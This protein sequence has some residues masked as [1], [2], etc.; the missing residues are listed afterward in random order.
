M[1][2]TGCEQ[3]ADAPKKSRNLAPKHN[4]LPPATDMVILGERKDPENLS[5][6]SAGGSLGST[7]SFDSVSLKCSVHS[8]NNSGVSLE[9]LQSHEGLRMDES[10]KEKTKTF[11]TSVRAPTPYPSRISHAYTETRDQVAHNAMIN[12]FYQEVLTD[13]LL[14]FF[15]ISQDIVYTDVQDKVLQFLQER[16]SVASKQEREDLQNF[17]ARTIVEAVVQQINAALSQAIQQCLSG[18]QFLALLESSEDYGEDGSLAG[19]SPEDPLITPSAMGRLR[20]LK[21]RFNCAIC[22]ISERVRNMSSCLKVTYKKAQQE[23]GLVVDLP[24]P[25]DKGTEV[26]LEKTASSKSSA[27]AISEW[28]LYHQEVVPDSPV[29]SETSVA[30]SKSDS[31]AKLSDAEA[32]SLS[33]QAVSGIPL[34]SEDEL[35]PERRLEILLSGIIRP[36]TN[37]LVNQLGRLLLVSGP[38][39]A[40]SVGGHSQSDSALPAS[41]MTGEP[42]TEISKEG[43]LAVAYALTEKS[44]Q[45]L[46]ER[47]LIALL[48]PSPVVES[49]TSCQDI[50]P[51]A[52]QQRIGSEV[53]QGCCNPLSVICRTIIDICKISRQV[54]EAVS[55][56]DLGLPVE[57]VDEM[58]SSHT[59]SV[60]TDSTPSV[61]LTK[62]DCCSSLQDKSSSQV[63]TSR[64]T[65]PSLTLNKFKKVNQVGVSPLP[66]MQHEETE[67]PA[68]ISYYSSF[69]TTTPDMASEQDEDCDSSRIQRNPSFLIR[70]YSTIEKP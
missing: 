44:I 35:S 33:E 51:A 48:P 13:P 62:C 27:T 56:V 37:M 18:T 19:V 25:A 10:A 46:L 15:G 55:E 17:S 29:C 58:F 39:K 68:E 36:H 1:E 45:A 49:A 61:S 23:Q 64:F 5:S 69:T 43:L 41:R 63:K 59:A 20:L 34:E 65:F 3:C 7:P 28:S 26:S 16:H 6:S 42:Q 57:N 38:P 70:I 52:A 47:L 50:G 8:G 21:L 2:K 4:G 24:A 40:S 60:H 66:T 32:L 12:Q 22:G 67:Y 11:S 30:K 9:Q 14:A 54:A 31:A 53:N